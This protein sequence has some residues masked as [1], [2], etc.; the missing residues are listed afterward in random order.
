MNLLWT[1]LNTKADVVAH[2]LLD[3]FFI[4]KTWD[5]EGDD[6]ATA[7]LGML[8]QFLIAPDAITLHVM[9]E[10]CLD[11]DDSYADYW[12]LFDDG[13]RINLEIEPVTMNDF[14]GY[15]IRILPLRLL[16]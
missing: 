10:T 8:T 2:R 1:V 9:T 15:K 16:T 6:L 13:S 4:P 3:G 7:I 14:P 12:V 11:N 5:I